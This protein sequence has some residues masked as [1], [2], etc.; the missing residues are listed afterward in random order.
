MHVSPAA[1]AKLARSS[2]STWL[3]DAARWFQGTSQLETRTSVYTFRDGVLNARARKPTRAFDTPKGA[4]GVRLVGF[5]SEDPARGTF[6]VSPRW[7]P[8]ACGLM[9]R[10]VGGAHLEA[11]ACLVT[12]ATRAF[13]REAR[14][15]A[16]GSGRRV[17]PANAFASRPVPPSFARPFAATG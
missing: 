6:D 8:G 3:A 7:Q 15:E 14:I 5:L 4:A 11:R 9:L 13:V 1:L 10:V 17:H 2:A 16:P 12:T